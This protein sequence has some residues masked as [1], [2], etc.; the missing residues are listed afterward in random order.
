MFMT[1]FL[2][3]SLLLTA[4][5]FFNVKTIFRFLIVSKCTK[6]GMLRGGCVEAWYGVAGG[7]DSAGS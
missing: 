6:I 1:D 4:Q 2:D 3:V 5:T 7:S